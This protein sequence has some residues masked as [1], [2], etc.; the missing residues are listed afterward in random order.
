MNFETKYGI[1]Y[2][3][4]SRKLLKNFDNE[5]FD[6]VITSPPYKDVDGYTEDLI[7]SVFSEVYRVQKNTLYYIL[8]HRL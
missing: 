1:L 8:H 7:F 3:G 4:D 6:L 2:N 5:Y